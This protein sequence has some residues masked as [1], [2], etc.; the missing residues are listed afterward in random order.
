MIYLYMFQYYIIQ[1]QEV[2][3]THARTQRRGWRRD[4]EREDTRQF[5]DTNAIKLHTDILIFFFFFALL[6]VHY[7]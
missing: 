6:T 5:I 3:R 4:R 1:V 2:T 7:M